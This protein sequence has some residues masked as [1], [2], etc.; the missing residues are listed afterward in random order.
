MITD[1]FKIPWKEIKR[2]KLR[3]WLT[4]IG[5]FIGISAIVSLITLGQGLENAIEQQFEALG[6][7]KLLISAKGDA[8]SAG[9]SIDAI[10]ITN[11]DMEVVSDTLGV[12]K[13]AGFIY[14]TVRVEYNDIVKYVYVW[15]M[16]TDPEERELIG[17][18]Q[19]FSVDAGRSLE[20]GDNNKVVLGYQYTQEKFLEKEV[21]LNDKVLINDEEFKVVGFL[22]KIGSPP[23]DQAVMITLEDYS[24]IFD[25]DDELGMIIAQTQP[26]EDPNDVS[27][28][29]EKALRKHRGLDEGEEDFMIQTPEQMMESF[30][31]IL[32]IIQIVLIGIAGISLLVGGVGIMNTMYTAVLQRTKEIGVMKA[33]GAK[34]SHVLYLFLIESGFY[35]LGGGIIGAAIGIGFAKS[36]EYL[37]TVFVGPAFLN[38][39]IDWML[40]LATLTFSFVV[41]CISGIAPARKA[42]KL[43]PVDS[44]RYE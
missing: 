38:I 16:P 36:V 39:E 35:G 44:L 5:V 24:D 12:K 22:E 27:E 26:G 33:L 6:K 31:V 2:R 1:Y 42:S 21:D 25:T 20:K 15:G 4:L 32:D 41:G 43:N 30:S 34:N 37:F 29:V 19:S 10:K 40:V 7:D 17:E 14:S 11:D 13:V 23:D 3:S 8:L 28:S 18:T 9:L